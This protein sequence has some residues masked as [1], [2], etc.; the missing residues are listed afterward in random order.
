MC[1]DKTHVFILTVRCFGH[2]SISETAILLDY[3]LK[4]I[5]IPELQSVF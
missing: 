4:T 1:H 3:R 2:M 5:H